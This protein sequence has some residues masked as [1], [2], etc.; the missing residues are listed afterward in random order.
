MT[1]PT[2]VAIVLG[3]A[4]TGAACAQS[5]GNV[6]G[7]IVWAN[8]VI[9]APKNLV[10][11]TPPANIPACVKGEVVL[12]DEL[13]IDKN[14]KGVAN[15]LVW[16]ASVQDR[17]N[18]QD[19]HP[20][21]IPIH[22][23]LKAVPK[24]KVVIDQ[25]CCLFEPRVLIIR[26]GQALEVRNNAAFSHSFQYTGHEEINGSKNSTVP[27]GGKAE[28]MLKA[29]K[30][31]IKIQCALHGWMT[32]EMLVVNHPYAAISK[33]DGTFEFKNAPAGKFLIFIFHETSGW[34]HNG[35]SKGQEIEIKAGQTLELGKFEMK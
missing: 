10:A 22:P 2:C 4:M 30:K 19:G 25:P 18:L 26:E 17:K 35:G 16:L 7:Q 15:V 8:P 5:W 12:S 23:D 6:K 13:L 31:P 29:Q 11:N 14:T 20:N 24:D 28:L 1:S 32:G 9:P 3:L 33:P 27:P 21:P 34:V